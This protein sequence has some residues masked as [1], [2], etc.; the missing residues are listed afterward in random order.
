MKKLKTTLALLLSL[1]LVFAALPVSIAAADTLYVNGVDILTDTDKKVVC[2]DGYA[3]YNE[4]SNTLTLTDATITEVSLYFARAIDIALTDPLTIILVGDNYIYSDYDGILSNGALTITGGGTLTV[5]CGALGDPD[6][7]AYTAISADE[8]IVDGVK[9]TLS[10]V[11]GSAMSIAN[12]I[13]LRNSAD[14]SCTA[15]KSAIYADGSFDMESNSKLDA[16]STS[17]NM[18][19]MNIS[20]VID[21]A[22]STVTL[23]SGYPAMFSVADIEVRNSNINI[24]STNDL[25]IWTIGTLTLTNCSGVSSGI[26]SS[27][28]VTISGGEPDITSDLAYM[29][30]IYSRDGEIIIKDGA[31]VTVTTSSS[32]A[33]TAVYGTNGVSVYDSSLNVTAAQDTAIYSESYI[34]ITNSIV[35]AETAAEGSYPAINSAGLLTIDNSEVTAVTQNNSQAIY[36]GDDINLYDSVIDAANGTGEYAILSSNMFIAN[37]CWI[38]STHGL[39]YDEIRYN[40]YELDGVAVIQYGKGIIFGDLVI[41]KDVEL[42]AGERLVVPVGTSLTVGATGSIDVNGELVIEDEAAAVING[43]LTVGSNG[44]M[45]VQGNT[46]IGTTGSM[47]VQGQVDVGTTGSM[48]VQG[49]VDVNDEGTLNNNGNTT[50]SGGSISNNGIINCTHHIGGE[51][52]YDSPA[53]CEICGQPYGD[54]LDAPIIII[55]NLTVLESENG[56]VELSTTVASPGAKVYI[57][58]V[59]DEGCELSDL[60]AV[61]GSGKSLTLTPE[62]DGSFSF[63]MPSGNVTVA[64]EFVIP[65]VEPNPPEPEKITFDDVLESDWYYSEISYVCENG[66]MNG[67]GGNLFAPNAA[68]TRAMTVTILSRLDGVESLEGDDW[69]VNGANWAVENRISDGTMLD[70]NV[71]REQLVTMIYRYAEYK[72]YY[73]DY[74][75]QLW[76]YPD[77]AD[78]SDWATEAF[79]WAIDKEMIT[80]RDTG[81]LDPQGEATRAE[82]AAIIVRYLT[83]RGLSKH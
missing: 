55:Y 22:D 71:T 73:T 25:S 33:Y 13:R 17:S 52:T 26:G 54:K 31:D 39:V 7:G 18:N 60:I 38:T 77:A 43:Q 24:E 34:D 40:W 20:G 5:E 50:I 79:N 30:G 58:A 36:S 67:I 37:N 53:I 8:L 83:P 56:S 49:Q 62:E 74:T 65:I 15:N 12:S 66:L 80:G 69:Y 1:L 41:D 27:G 75:E 63:T 23:S 21:I 47:N 6:D 70:A 81:E 19:A 61:D 51:A 76:A 46:E 4:E 28:N 11:A 45:N 78:V 29:N 10:S 68:L 2:G 42:K 16:E 57:T 44:V 82:A 9:L 64:A 32:D 72:G 3:E 35:Y 48:N 14:V 59:P